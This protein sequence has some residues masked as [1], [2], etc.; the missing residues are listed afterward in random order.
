ML[1]N[2]VDLQTPNHNTYNTLASV[3]SITICFPSIYNYVDAYLIMSATLI[4]NLS[5]WLLDR[6]VS[7]CMYSSLSPLPFG[8]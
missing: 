1:F 6:R 4:F 5:N 3:W 7:L 2:S 8:E